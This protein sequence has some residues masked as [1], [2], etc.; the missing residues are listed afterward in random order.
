M[1]YKITADLTMTVADD[2]ELHE[3]IEQIQ[4]N[5]GSSIKVLVL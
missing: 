4:A 3:K 1:K 5:G 2:A